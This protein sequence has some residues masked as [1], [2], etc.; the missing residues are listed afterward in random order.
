MAN[1]HAKP[2][3]VS[4]CDWA[5]MYSHHVDYVLNLLVKGGWSE[6]PWS[7]LSC[8]KS[9]NSNKLPISRSIISNNIILLSLWWLCLLYCNFSNYATSFLG[10]RRDVPTQLGWTRIELDRMW[11]HRLDDRHPGQ[12]RPS[13][14]GEVHGLLDP[15]RAA[16]LAQDGTGMLGKNRE[17][18]GCQASWCWTPFGPLGYH[19]TWRSHTLHQQF[20]G[21]GRNHGPFILEIRQHRQTIL[22]GSESL[23]FILL[24]WANPLVHS[25]LT[26][27]SWQSEPCCLSR[28]GSMVKSYQSLTGLF[29]AGSWQQW[30]S[31]TAARVVF[32]S[33]VPHCCSRSLA[34]RIP[35]QLL[36]EMKCLVRPLSLCHTPKASTSTSLYFIRTTQPIPW[37]LY[38]IHIRARLWF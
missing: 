18:P 1:P 38:P 33:A 36:L 11:Q 34:S 26:K 13:A 19:I 10:L 14:Q 8:R 29:D 7:H 24:H 3:G 22:R 30:P 32:F 15:D 2:Q 23:Q 21:L 17:G 25:K 37:L 28:S 16:A 12:H 5:V 4:F 20:R 27:C 31:A 35:H 9:S 6:L